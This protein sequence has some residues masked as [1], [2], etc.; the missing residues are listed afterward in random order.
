MR[1]IANRAAAAPQ[2]MPR[3][4][5][6]SLDV[7][8]ETTGTS[9]TIA[10]IAARPIRMRCAHCVPSHAIISRLPNKCADDAAHRVRR[11]QTRSDQ[12]SGILF[13]HPRLPRGRA[14]SWR[15]QRHAGGEHRPQATHHV[16]LELVAWVARQSRR[17]RPVRNL[18]RHRVRC[19]GNRSRIRS[20]WQ[21]PSAV[22]GSLSCRARMEPT[23]LPMPK[24]NRKAARISEKVYV[25][26]P[27]QQ[28]KQPG[29][30]GLGG[31]VPSFL[32]DRW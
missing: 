13:G 2:T 28:R 19:P 1:R 22:L 20:N 29:P 30:H 16:D 17:H 6:T 5:T 4:L 24:P 9:I 27:E 15:P 25:V 21:T 26:A 8:S 10:L 14:G 23:L 7:A 31:P 18:A 3:D 11:V 12:P 32:T